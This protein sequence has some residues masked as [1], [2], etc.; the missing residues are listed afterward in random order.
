LGNVWFGPSGS[1]LQTASFCES[2]LPE[3]IVDAW[4][5]YTPRSLAAQYRGRRA[6]VSF[7][8]LMHIRRNDSGRRSRFVGGVLLL[9]A[10]VSA[11]ASASPASSPALTILAPRA[12][13]TVTPPWA[14]RYSIAGLTVGAAHPARIRVAIAGQSSGQTP[15]SLVVKRA[16]GVVQIPD[17]RFWSGRRD[18][19]FTLV[20]G[21]GTAYPG[22]R[23][24]YTVSGLTIAGGR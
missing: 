18:V 16:R 3:P 15:L 1:C 19:V 5:A 12:G 7:S 21:D 24:S 23:S 8:A 22:S 2:A 9:A 4:L 11:G 6:R 20:R 13:Q 10:S 14:V 17:N